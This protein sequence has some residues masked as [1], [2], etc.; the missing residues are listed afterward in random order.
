[1]FPLVLVTQTLLFPLWRACFRVVLYGR[2]LVPDPATE[3]CGQRYD[4]KAGS[5]PCCQVAE[6][7]AKKHQKV[8]LKIYFGLGNMACYGGTI[9][10]FTSFSISLWSKNLG[11]TWQQWLQCLR[12]GGGRSITT[13]MHAYSGTHAC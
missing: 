10:V 9:S 2:I 6:H 5:S 11:K 4:R 13:R 8:M 3:P 1:M 12:G 7:S